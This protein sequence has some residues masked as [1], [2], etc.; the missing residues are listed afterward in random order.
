MGNRY[1]KKGILEYKD[2]LFLAFRNSENG[3]DYIIIHCDNDPRFYYIRPFNLLSND[4][5]PVKKI[6]QSA[7][8]EKYGI[9]SNNMSDIDL[10]NFIQVNLLHV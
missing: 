9:S 2:A 7:I 3:G 6:S 1:S 8:V 5:Q 10:R 4:E